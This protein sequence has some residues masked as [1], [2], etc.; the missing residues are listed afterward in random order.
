M[1]ND[2]P[3]ST[4]L[5]SGIRGDLIR[6]EET[7]I[8]ALIERAQYAL[9]SKCYKRGES[10]VLQERIK[11]RSEGAEECLSDMSFME[12][13]MLETESLHAKLGRYNSPD[14]NAFF[15]PLLPKSRVTG[16][17]KPSALKPN[18]ININ[19]E[20]MQVYTS[21]FLNDLCVQE[22]DGEY[23]S[24][25]AVDI[26]VLQSLSKRIHYGKFVA[27]AKFQAERERFSEMINNNDADGIMAAL[28]NIT[29]EDAVVER[30][31]LKASR[32]GSDVD[33]S[34]YKVQ[35][36]VIAKLYRDYLIPLNKNVQVEYL[37]SRLSRPSFAHLKGDEDA[38]AAKFSGKGLECASIPDVFHAVSRNQV[39]FGVIPI[40]D[41]DR[42]F[43]KATQLSLASTS[44]KV[45][46]SIK[47]GCDSVWTRYYIISTINPV[48]K[49]A[50]S[51]L[52]TMF[53]VKDG[54]GALL[55]VLNGLGEVNLCSLESIHTGVYGA[56]VSFFCEIEAKALTETDILNIISKLRAETKFVNLVGTY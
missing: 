31:R 49:E 17:F 24:T 41:S 48:K 26:T 37:L 1:D 22:D 50:K 30:V 34:A 16:H 6:Q 18:R 9:N 38:A 13:F 45:C 10:G 29:V 14:E 21:K 40:E 8:F 47:R 12:Y 35:P 4:L 33:D 54:P 2:E 36:D 43:F 55:K 42:G 44:L 15:L 23:G 28:T 52:V 5:L 46:G 25:C 7:I 51:H 20:V 32:Y 27:E 56:E 19:E 53:S 3:S 11:Y 39:G